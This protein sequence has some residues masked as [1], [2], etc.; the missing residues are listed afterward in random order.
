[1]LLKVLEE[2][3]KQSAVSFLFFNKKEKPLR[4]RTIGVVCEALGRVGGRSSIPLL[5][6]FAGNKARPWAAAAREAIELIEK[7]CASKEDQGDKA[8]TAAEPPACPL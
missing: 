4:D 5:K 3:G 6:E 2:R 1:V 7:R 8:T